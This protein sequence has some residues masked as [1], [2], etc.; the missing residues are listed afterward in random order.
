[1]LQKIKLTSVF[2]FII[3]I[4]ATHNSCCKPAPCKA[5][6]ADEL[7]WIPYKD[8]DSVFFKSNLTGR[9]YTLIAKKVHETTL[10]THDCQEGQNYCDNYLE[11]YFKSTD[12]LALGCSLNNTNNYNNKKKKYYQA[13]FIFEGIQVNIANQNDSNLHT[14]IINGITYSN[15]I[16]YPYGKYDTV[17]YA[18]G[19]GIVAYYL[20]ATKEWLY[21]Q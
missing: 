4:I 19:V 20:T 17:Y 13:W 15:T 8:G 2:I 14:K 11:M 6:S 12:T 7:A 1:M 21:K 10:P 3:A 5:F 9:K 18:K 16:V